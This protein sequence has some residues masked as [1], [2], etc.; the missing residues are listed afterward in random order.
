[1]HYNTFDMIKQDAHAWAKEVK[2]QT[3]VNALVPNPGDWI[4]L[5]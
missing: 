4:D 3:G 1:M 5:G 2:A